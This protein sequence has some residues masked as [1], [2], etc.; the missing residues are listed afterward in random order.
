MRVIRQATC[1]AIRCSQVAA[2]T[3]MM[4]QITAGMTGGK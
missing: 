3:L 4:S 1:A 2:S